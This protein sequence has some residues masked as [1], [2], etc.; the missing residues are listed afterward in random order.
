MHI[1]AKSVRGNIGNES[2]LKLMLIGFS[3]AKPYPIGLVLQLHVT[4]R[5][6]GPK[7]IPFQPCARTSV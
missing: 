1:F 4:L 6:V 3:D 7:C 2:M 5:W